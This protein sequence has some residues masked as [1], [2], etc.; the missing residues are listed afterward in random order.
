MRRSGWAHPQAE[1]SA[2]SSARF[3]YSGLRLSARLPLSHWILSQAILPLAMIAGLWRPMRC[4]SAEPPKNHGLRKRP[5]R[6]APK[7]ALPSQRHFRL[8]WP[9]PSPV[10]FAEEQLPPEALQNS[11]PWLPRCFVNYRS[12]YAP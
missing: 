2:P 9:L 12:K 4:R 10:R 8:C 5:V 1:A 11:A 6:I 7:I 3:Q